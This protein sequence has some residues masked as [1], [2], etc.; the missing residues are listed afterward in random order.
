M[1][2]DP[3]EEWQRLIAAY[4]EKFDGELFEL[5]R[6]YADLT[7]GAQQALRAEMQSRGLGDP[8]AQRVTPKAIISSDLPSS[9]RLPNVIVQQEAGLFGTG[10]QMPQLVP[11]SREAEQDDSPHDY[12][13]KTE[14]CELDTPEEA[15]QLQEVLKRAS[16]ES[17]IRFNGFVYAYVPS[18][19]GAIRMGLGGLQVLVPADR[20]D[21][22][23]DIASKPIPQDIVDE[24]KEEV[25]DYVEPKCPQCGT[26]D[27]T[28]ESAEP[29]NH[30][31]CEDCGAEWNDP[32]E[33]ANA[34]GE[35]PEKP[36]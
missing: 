33:S 5:A 29:V 25:P 34:A 7:P 10:S 14:L 3:A 16:I 19:Q 24:S 13:W 22:A 27:P 30:W 23:R 15:S 36:S 21:E 8:A 35:P 11:D 17:W 9:Q 4:R 28:L 6:D 31:R 1:Q 32:V 20:L 26:E 18:M 12:T 2:I